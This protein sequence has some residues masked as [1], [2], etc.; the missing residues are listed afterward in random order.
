MSSRNI[1]PEARELLK[2]LGLLIS[3]ELPMSVQRELD[4]I[5]YID[6]KL[7]EYKTL[8]AKYEES[9]DEAKKPHEKATYNLLVYEVHEFID[10]LEHIKE[11]ISE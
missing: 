2:E 11:E 7:D 8:L 6:L 5:S 1:G 10:V 9:R 4:K 3:K